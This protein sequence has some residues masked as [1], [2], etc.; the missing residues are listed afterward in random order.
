LIKRMRHEQKKKK[1][2]EKILRTREKEDVKTRE[3][4]E[5]DTEIKKLNAQ[6]IREVR[7]KRKGLKAKLLEVKRRVQRKNR[8]IEQRIQK[9]RGSMANELMLANKQGDWKVCK[10]S[11]DSKNKMG[12]YCNANFVDNFNKNLECKDPENF[13]YICCENEYGNMYLQKRD[14]CYTMCDQL[15]KTDLNNGSWVWHDDILRKQ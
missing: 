4:M 2:L 1:C 9:I 8:I 15:H 13:C 14:K 3:A 11:R 5:I 7:K 6:A 10:R 12:E